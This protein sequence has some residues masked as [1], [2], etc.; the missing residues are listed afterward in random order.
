MHETCIQHLG[1]WLLNRPKR[2][3]SSIFLELSAFYLTAST[4]TTN[5]WTHTGSPVCLPAK[6]QRVVFSIG[7][8][9]LSNCRKDHSELSCFLESGRPSNPGW[10]T[11]VIFCLVRS[12]AKRK[13]KK[14]ERTAGK[15]CSRNNMS[16]YY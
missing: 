7:C 11:I 10:V 15:S 13:K 5:R 3:K 9:S 8:V 2:L 4:V 16:L 12:I 14:K 6:F 1:E